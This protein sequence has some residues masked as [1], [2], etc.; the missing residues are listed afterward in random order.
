MTTTDPQQEDAILRGFMGY[1]LKRAMNVFSS[2][3]AV[4]LKPFDLR[5]IT[6]STLASVVN[7]PGV[8]LSQ[9]AEILSVER[10]NLV[11]IVDELQKR[12]LI[13]RKR[14][15]NDRRAFGL[16]PTKAGQTLLH[17]A[18]QNVDL[19]ERKILET[20]SDADMEHLT[21][22]LAKIETAAKG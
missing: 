9:L 13:E 12:N 3:L 14:D 10:P 19:S 8:R 18:M 1:R 15:P 20:F 11:A 2:N 22:L 6:F 16:F 7:T 4:V 5:M 21:S 17:E